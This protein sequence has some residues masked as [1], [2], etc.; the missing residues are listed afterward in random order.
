MNRN[1]G[2]CLKR[3]GNTHHQFKSGDNPN[4]YCVM[5]DKFVPRKRDR[6][7]VNPAESCE[8]YNP[9]RGVNDAIR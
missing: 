3:G 5:L 9:K 2:D 7:G 4:A 1:C 6:C 8:F